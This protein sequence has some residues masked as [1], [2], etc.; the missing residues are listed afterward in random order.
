MKIILVPTDFSKEA[1]NAGEYAAHLAKE[2]KAKL[3]LFHTY[4]IPIPISE[5]PVMVVSEKEM[6]K[7]YE[8]RLKNEAEYLVEKINVNVEYKAE[9]GLTA[10]AILEE[11]KE[12]FITVMGMR[13]AGKISEA[14]IG[15]TA[16]TTLRKSKKPLLVIPKNVK[17]KKPKK[18][19]FACDYDPKTDI[20]TIE[21]LKSFVKIFDSEVLIVNIQ[22]KEE[23]VLAGET[24]NEIK[25]D[26]KLKN[27][28]HKFYFSKNEDLV[29]GINEFVKEHKADMV[30][31]IPH[32]YYLLE[33]IF[34][35]SISK[36][37]AFHTNVPL[38]SI[39]DNHKLIPAYLI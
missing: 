3:L 10:D 37:M 9:M 19:V 21:V 36:K 25:I 7:N 39:P 5:V 14:L 35:K 15:S 8:E 22:K 16:T 28:K 13:G 12:A 32:H 31:I 2:L 18:I 33:N 1:R 6:Q 38:L 27:T 17:Y 4:Q 29:E 24:F 23:P 34:H 11:E 30:A 26:I 20:S